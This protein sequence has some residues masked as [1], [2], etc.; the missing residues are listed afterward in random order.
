MKNTSPIAVIGAMP[1]EVNALTL[2][3]T[4]RETLT[5]AGVV[6]HHGQ[7]N[8]Q[9]VVVT[10]S[11]IGK[12]NASIATTLVIE[13]FAPRAVINTGSAG[14]IGKGLMVG[15]IVIGDS[16][17]HHDVDV[18]AFG[19]QMG[20]M[21]DMPAGYPSD[22]QLI[23]IAKSSAKAFPNAY[24]HRGQI[25]SGDQ[26]IATSERFAAIKKHFPKALAVEMEAAAIAQ[27][28]YRFATPF[29]VVR[30]ISDLANEQA[31]QSFDEFIEQAGRHSA[32]MVS[33]MI[34]DLR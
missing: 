27:T 4:N 3:L 16:V 5:T 31:E 33:A 25:V 14:G 15:D 34:A 2:Q 21:A 26:F 30:A 29:V 11:G 6:M 18:T 22:S 9:P 24:I 12:V 7:L 20:Q 28:C 19:Y 13:H 1:Q 10:Q 17:A 8:G 32:A 23:N